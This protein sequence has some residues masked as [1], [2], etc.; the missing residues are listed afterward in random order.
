MEAVLPQLDNLILS[1][2]ALMGC[3]FAAVTILIFTGG[4]R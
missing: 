4:R 3:I 1:M 2:H